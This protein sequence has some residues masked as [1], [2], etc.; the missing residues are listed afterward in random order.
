M[1][2][3][4]LSVY[5][6]RQINYIQIDNKVIGRYLFVEIRKEHKTCL[7]SGKKKTTQKKTKVQKKAS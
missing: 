4:K 2:L 3:N 1:P 7:N 6:N 5:I